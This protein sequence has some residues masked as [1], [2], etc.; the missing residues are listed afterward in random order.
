MGSLYSEAEYKQKI[1]VLEEKKNLLVQ[2]LKKKDMMCRFLEKE[3]ERRDSRTMFQEF[4]FRLKKN[5]WD[6]EMTG[7]YGENLTWIIHIDSPDTAKMCL[8][9][10]RHHPVFNGKIII[11][12]SLLLPE[13]S[14]EID[15]I[16]SQYEPD[17]IKKINAEDYRDGFCALV[18]F[19]IDQIETEWI[20][21]LGS[22]ARVREPFAGGIRNELIY[23]GC[24]FINL[25]ALPCDSMNCVRQ[26]VAVDT[27]WETDGE[28]LIIPGG[29]E[30]VK[31]IPEFS[32]TFTTD[33]CVFRKSTFVDFGMYNCAY[34]ALTGREFADRIFRHNYAIA[35]FSS[36]V[37]RKPDNNYFSCSEEELKKYNAEIGKLEISPQTGPSRLRVAL[38]AD[39]EGWAYH[40]I[41]LQ[42]K[43]NLTEM[44]IDIFYS[45]HADSIAELFL[46]L[47]N[48]D[49]VHVLWRGILQ[50]LDSDPFYGELC[51][52][53]LTREEYAKKFIG[54][55]CLTTAVYDHLY[56]GED[57]EGVT[58]KILSAVDEY[59]V[60][61]AKLLD[62][63]SKRYEKKPAAEISDGVDL[64]MFYPQNLERFD[65]IDDRPVV[66][67]WVGNSIF[68]GNKA[69]DLKGV[70]TILIPAVDELRR[71]GENVTR[72]FADRQERI[73]PHSEMKDYYSKI[74]IY[75][76]TSRI[77]GTPNPLLE[78]MACG[79]PVITTD[80][81]LVPEVLGEFQKQFVLERRDI[82]CLKDAVRRMIS[83]PDNLKR[84]S[85]ENLRQIRDW[86]WKIKCTQY[87]DFFKAAYSR[88]VQKRM[89]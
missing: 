23:S 54:G 57:T 28:H 45:R 64:E 89:E 48:Y 25:P 63:Y 27:R 29:K 7:P 6:S 10:C 2:Q 73:I 67:G 46:L 1:A 66:I 52:Y 40:N 20:L 74:D 39:E 81:G 77:E 33:S 31:Q 60:S 13:I 50:F 88:K 55:L 18:N 16:L 26:R 22:W 5:G 68:W 76:C 3:K 58:E 80:V 44:D 70:H 69:D 84:C 12:D 19:L 11:A 34:G 79:V 56:L 83:S 71:E 72:L 59:T 15:R 24:H 36:A 49:V 61:S 43:K 75:V 53:G 42:L 82:S 62:I 8:S 32:R 86:S 21:C 35:N 87:G 41:A 65:R 17:S 38:I 9:F 85:E 14:S 51:Q 78:A 30:T 4:S 47:K 37:L